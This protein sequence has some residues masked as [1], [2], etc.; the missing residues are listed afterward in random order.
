MSWKRAILLFFQHL[1]PSSIFFFC[2]FFNL[3]LLRIWTKNAHTTNDAHKSTVVCSFNDFKMKI[4][5]IMVFFVVVFAICILCSCPYFIYISRYHAPL[6]QF[7]W[8]AFLLFPFCIYWFCNE[9]KKTSNAKQ[10]HTH[11]DRYLSNAIK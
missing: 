11:K 9:K 4:H 8:C 7:N 1:Q 10:S 6:S 2:F 3:L 5:I